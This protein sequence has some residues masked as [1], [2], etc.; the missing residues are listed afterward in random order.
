MRRADRA[1]GEYDF[2]AACGAAHHTILPEAHAAGAQGAGIAV[3]LDG[4]GETTGLQ[5]QVRA[6]ERRLE[7]AAR[8]GPA[9]AASRVDVE[10]ADA[11]VVAGVEVGALR[12]AVFDRGPLER[13]QNVPCQPLLLNAPVAALCVLRA[14]EEM[15][16]V[17]AKVRPHV[18]PRPAG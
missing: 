14:G 17:L 10:I 4:L 6:M 13:F 12:N 11:F 16:D 9:P 3:E 5:P 15:S 1:G 8:G 7:E 2:A 18:V